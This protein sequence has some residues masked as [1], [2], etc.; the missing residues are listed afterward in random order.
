MISIP[1]TI[2]II[3]GECEI[4]GIANDD[5]G[6]KEVLF[7]VDDICKSIVSQE[8]YTWKWENYSP[9]LKIYKLTMEAHDIYGNNAKDEILVRIFNPA[10][11]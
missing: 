3:L 5:S 11:F 4:L 7:Y 2:P 10:L 6:I 8:P 1:C 9:V